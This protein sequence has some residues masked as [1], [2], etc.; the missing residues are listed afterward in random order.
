MAQSLLQGLVVARIILSKLL[1][2]RTLHRKCAQLPCTINEVSGEY[3][4]R[5]CTDILPSKQVVCIQ[6]KGKLLLARVDQVSY[7]VLDEADRMLDLGF[8][9]HIRSIA[10]Q[11][12]A[13]RQ[14]LMFSATWPS[15]VQR[16]AM[17]YL[18]NPARVVIGS[19]SLSAS[20]SV[21]QVS[22]IQQL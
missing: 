1:S 11:T 7:L 4:N 13:D 5:C 9:P 18:A 14:T 2:I 12:R 15:E 3:R 22:S 17:E 8:E 16:L 6:A 21:S 10:T 19:H 20:H